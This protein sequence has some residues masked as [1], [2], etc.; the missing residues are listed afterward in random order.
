MGHCRSSNW[1]SVTF[2]FGAPRT[3]RSCGI[4]SSSVAASWIPL[5]S[6]DPPPPPFES[7]PRSSRL[8]PTSTR[9]TAAAA[10]A[11][12]RRFLF[13]DCLR[14]GG[15]RGFGGIGRQSAC[16]CLG[17]VLEPSISRDQLE[18][19]LD[20]VERA[21]VL[22]RG[23]VRDDRHGAGSVGKRDLGVE[24]APGPGPRGRSRESPL[25]EL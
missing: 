5:T 22:G 24:R 16:G 11:A 6:P 25:Q 23:L 21:P 7:P 3:A 4:P 12:I 17:A 1:I 14:G 10:P 9:T 13:P 18:G 20:D 2:A 8:A 15:L 19:Q